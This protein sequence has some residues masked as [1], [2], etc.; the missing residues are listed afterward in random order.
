M[1]VDLN[2]ALGLHRRGLPDRA[3]RGYRAL[4]AQDPDHA[5]AL[6]LLGVIALQRGQP[7]RAVEDIGR[8]VALNPGVAGYQ[9]NLAEVYRALG[10]H[11]RA[12]ECCRFA[13]ALRSHFPAAANNLGLTWLSAVR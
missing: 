1:S 9:A 5:D 8:G 3:A 10:Q 11:E 12:V 6:H 7:A 13:L 2:T 4:L